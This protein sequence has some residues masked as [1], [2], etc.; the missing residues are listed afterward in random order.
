MIRILTVDKAN[1]KIFIN[2]EDVLYFCSDKIT[3]TYTLKKTYCI[4]MTLKELENKLSDNFKRVH[5]S[6][7]VDLTKV[8]SVKLESHN[9]SLKLNM[10]NNKEVVVSRQYQSIIKKD[11]NYI[12]KL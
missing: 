6:S 12:K 4:R 7:I 9:R 2:I 5:R 1:E 3:L 11:L 8:K 10:I